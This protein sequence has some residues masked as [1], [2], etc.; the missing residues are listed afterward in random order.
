MN[1]RSPGK[2]AP[3]GSQPAL[4]SRQALVQGLPRPA[5]LWA[6]AA[7][8][9][10][11]GG[12]QRPHWAG[13]WASLPAAARPCRARPCQARRVAGNAGRC[14]GLGR[15]SAGERTG[16]R[17]SAGPPHAGDGWAQRPEPASSREKG[18][19]PRGREAAGQERGPDPGRAPGRPFPQ[20]AHWQGKPRRTFRSEIR[21]TFRSET[22]KSGQGGKPRVNRGRSGVHS[23]G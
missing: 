14:S 18:P 7:V 22:G 15:S 8:S 13:D 10:A 3:R 2:G 4:R 1:A 16:A 17:G 20:R 6:G 12:G 5:V 23:Q 9:A 21:G 11:W 19:L